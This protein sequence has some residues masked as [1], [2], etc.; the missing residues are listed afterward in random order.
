MCINTRIYA[1]KNS[2][3]PRL[4]V[5]AFLF[6][7]RNVSRAK[8]ELEVTHCGVLKKHKERMSFNE[9]CRLR[10]TLPINVY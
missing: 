5:F 9:D 3:V 2:Y 7:C 4:H 6:T 1:Y 8:L 10:Y